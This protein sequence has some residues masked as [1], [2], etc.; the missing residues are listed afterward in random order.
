MAIQTAVPVLWP[1]PYSQA[2][3]APNFTAT[4]SMNASGDRI[5]F[6]VQIPKSGTLD[7]FELR[8][9]AMANNPDNGIRF[10]FQ[11]VAAATGNPDGVQDQFRDYVTALVANTWITP[12]LITSD[13]T[14]TGAKRSVTRGQWVACV[15]DFVSFVASDS[16]SISTLRTDTIWGGASY[17]ADGTT[18]SYVKGSAS[19]VPILALKY[20]DGTYAHFGGDMVFPIQTINTISIGT[21]STPDEVAMK[22]SLP[23]K[24]RVAGAWFWMNNAQDAEVILYDNASSVLAN[25]VYDKDLNIGGATILPRRVYFSSSIQLSAGTTY[26]LALKP[27]A[28]STCSFYSYVCPSSAYM[29]AMPWGAGNVY[30]SRTD[31]GAW[32]DGTA[33]QLLCGL[34]LDGL[35]DDAGG[36]GG[37]G[38]RGYIG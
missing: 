16:F 22:F 11:D 13:G 38:T 28:A 7:K 29:D 36:G 12:G 6:I 32:S 24:A 34:I 30:S 2:A 23:Y 37:G 9:S 8:I 1:L 20:D 5:A 27:Q 33:E 3:T 31:A 10:S 19:M 21:G 4:G 26:R 25:H 18:G 35:S 14:D 15:I 17:S